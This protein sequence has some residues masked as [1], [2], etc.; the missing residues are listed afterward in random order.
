M[1]PGTR[2]H[3][4][5][6]LDVFCVGKCAGMRDREQAREWAGSREKQ[7]DNESERD[8]GRELNGKVA[9]GLAEADS[10]RAKSRTGSRNVE[11]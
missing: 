4:S 3:K 9:E 1:G 2:A 10:R 7:Q 8:S 6:Q 11:E 5:T